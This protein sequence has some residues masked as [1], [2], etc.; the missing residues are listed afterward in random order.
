MF[1]LIVSQAF[2]AVML[3]YVNSYSVNCLQV[4]G[5]FALT[6]AVTMKCLLF[7]FYQSAYFRLF[8]NKVGVGLWE[9]GGEVGSVEG[10]HSKPLTRIADC[11]DSSQLER[12]E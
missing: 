7:L 11:R 6:N 4:L 9:G 12:N 8:L 3:C 10:I 1:Q 2:L 5:V